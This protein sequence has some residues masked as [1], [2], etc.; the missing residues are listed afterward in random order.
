MNTS[1]LD[2][3]AT[4]RPDVV[5]LDGLKTAVEALTER[6]GGLEDSHERAIE[7]GALSGELGEIKSSIEQLGAQVNTFEGEANWKGVIEAL[8]ERIDGFEG[9]IAGGAPAGEAASRKTLAEAMMSTDEWKSYTRDATDNRLIA[10]HGGQFGRGIPIGTSLSGVKV[11]LTTSILD[12]QELQYRPGI[13]SASLEAMNIAARIMRQA[14]PGALTWATRRE[15]EASLTGYAVSTLAADI[16]GDPTPKNTCDLASADGFLPGVYVRFWDANGDLL[17]RV[18]VASIDY[19]ANE[20]TFAAGALDFD[21]TTGWRVTSEFFGAT[22]EASSKPYAFA[23]IQTDQAALKTIA[24]MMAVS[25]QVLSSP[26]S[27]QA[28]LENQ[29]R[30]RSMRN[31]SWHIFHG[32]GTQPEQLAGFDNYTGAQSYAWSAGEVGD[33]RFDAVAR[34]FALMPWTG[35]LVCAL[36]KLDLIKMMLVKGTDG[37]YITSQMFGQLQVIATGGR[38]FLG[39]FELVLDDAVIEGDFYSINMSEASELVDAQTNTLM[40]GYIDDQF[41]RN[42]ITARYEERLYH[43]I[44][45][46]RAFV[47]GE[48]D[49]APT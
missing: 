9:I 34:A 8:T 37:H 26:P 40:W 13:F 22:A 16:D 41:A 10:P 23:Q 35:E 4:N 19:A 28:W 29:L 42:M 27:L 6:V 14:A 1:D 7:R 21:A 18:Q 32:D 48:W 39:P 43:D 12:H 44:H 49:S 24:T 11:D 3:K 15:T 20:L 46:A 30:F 25:T 45:T 47:L 38:V 17:K 33:N 36:N 31:L 5:G 2:I